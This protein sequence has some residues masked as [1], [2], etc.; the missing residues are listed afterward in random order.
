MHKLIL[1]Y[2]GHFPLL[3]TSSISAYRKVYTNKAQVKLVFLF[4]GWT[5]VTKP[6]VF[7]KARV[8]QPNQ[9]NTQSDRHHC[10]KLTRLQA[11]ASSYLLWASSIRSNKSMCKTPL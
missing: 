6:M 2:D 4:N 9:N 10:Y 11:L 5:K 1:A 8:V 3:F 7:F